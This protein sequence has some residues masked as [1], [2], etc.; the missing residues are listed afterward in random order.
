[1]SH[2]CS[3]GGIVWGVIFSIPLWLVLIWAFSG[4]EHYPWGGVRE[5]GQEDVAENATTASTTTT[6]T[7]EQGQ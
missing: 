4:C 2:R 5:L 1:M 3:D 6:T 7:R